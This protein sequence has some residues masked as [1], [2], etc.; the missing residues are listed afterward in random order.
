MLITAPAEWVS[1]SFLLC[2]HLHSLPLVEHV[3]SKA[4]DIIKK[5]YCFTFWLFP[6]VTQTTWG[7]WLNWLNRDVLVTLDPLNNVTGR[8]WRCWRQSWILLL[9]LQ[10]ATG[11]QTFKRRSSGIPSAG[12]RGSAAS[13]RGLTHLSA[14]QR[15]LMI[16]VSSRPGAPWAALVWSPAPSRSFIK[17]FTAD[18]TMAA[19]W[20]RETHSRD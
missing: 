6:D 18:R 5:I 13:L 15:A 3:L 19:P 14:A 4:K 12:S 7:Q 2:L 20:S 16:P 1:R 10:E 11:Q 9:L 17:D 8:K